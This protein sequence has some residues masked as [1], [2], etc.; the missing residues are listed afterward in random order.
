MGAGGAGVVVLL[1]VIEAWAECRKGSFTT[2]T[3][4][5]T[6]ICAL[7]KATKASSGRTTLSAGLERI[8]HFLQ[9]GKF[10]NSA[11]R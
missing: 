8:E 1:Y 5:P 3:L 9:R 11:G 4:Q 6:A 7:K 2:A 10:R